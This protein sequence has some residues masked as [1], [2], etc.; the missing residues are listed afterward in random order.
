MSR[1]SDA[2]IVRERIAK[3]LIVAKN[4]TD[5]APT[6]LIAGTGALQATT[7]D[8]PKTQES[9]VQT[10]EATPV[11]AAEE[12]PPGLQSVPSTIVAGPPSV[13]PPAMPEVTPPAKWA[14]LSVT[15]HPGDFAIVDQQTTQARTAGIRLRRGGN[16]SIFVRAGLRNLEALRLTNPSAWAE[17]IRSVASSERPEAGR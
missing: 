10:S 13:P 5:D 7:I 14:K 6:T 11:A 15:L 9:G 2:A 12:A 3:N 1:A 4:A 16:P 8:S 17:L